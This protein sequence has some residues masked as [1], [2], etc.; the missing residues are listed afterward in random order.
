L[1]RIGFG[2]VTGVRSHYRGY[3]R[4]RSFSRPILPPNIKAMKTYYRNRGYR[5]NP[6]L[7]NPRFPCIFTF[8][9]PLPNGS[10]MHGEVVQSERKWIVKTH[11]DIADPYREPL[12]HLRKDLEVRHRDQIIKIRKPSE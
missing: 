3:P 10:R 4:I 1:R 12:R 5:I 7:Q 11:K 6:M 2:R 8:D 9:K